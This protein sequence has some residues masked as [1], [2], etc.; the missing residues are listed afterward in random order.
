MGCGK[1]GGGSSKKG[2]AWRRREK[3]G[4]RRQGVNKLFGCYF[5][6]PQV[7]RSGGGVARSWRTVGYHSKVMPA[8]FPI[9]PSDPFTG[10]FSTWTWRHRVSDWVRGYPLGRWGKAQ[11]AGLWRTIPPY[12]SSS[13]HCCLFS[14]LSYRHSWADALST[15][16]LPHVKY[17]CPHA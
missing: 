5:S 15:I 14:L 4:G 2:A 12:L 10:Y 6:S 11:W 13:P 7:L 8:L 16:R 1:N 9:S 17:I 3:P